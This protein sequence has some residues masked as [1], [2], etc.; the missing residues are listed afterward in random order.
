MRLANSLEDEQAGLTKLEQLAESK[1]LD[2]NITK[3]CAIVVGAKKARMHLKEELSK[4]PLK[5]YN[6][7]LATKKC[8]KYL[9][10][11]LNEEGVSKCS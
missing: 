11:Y 3:T 2:Y 7:D 5:L 10:W 6:K 8:D 4:N 9:G 1:L